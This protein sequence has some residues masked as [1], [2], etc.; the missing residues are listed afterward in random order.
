MR[1]SPS[2][3]YLSQL[4]LGNKV[5]FFNIYLMFRC[6][7]NMTRKCCECN[8]TASEG[9]YCK[10]YVTETQQNLKNETIYGML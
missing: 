8:G 4:P 9:S 7:N 1:S 3:E 10:R 2:C 5:T 6:Y